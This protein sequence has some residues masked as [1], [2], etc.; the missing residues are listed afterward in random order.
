LR[1]LRVRERPPSCTLITSRLILP[2]AREGALLCPARLPHFLRT[3][4]ESDFGFQPSIDDPRPGGSTDVQCFM[5]WSSRQAGPV[6]ARSA[7][8]R[9]RAWVSFRAGPRPAEMSATSWAH[10][11]LIRVTTH[12]VGCLPASWLHRSSHPRSVRLRR[13]HKIVRLRV[14]EYWR[15]S[16]HD[17]DRIEG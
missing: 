9:I 16:S 1:A 17:C 4:H 3:L 10:S 5:I 8:K 14:M 2:A 11:R 7:F 12:L 13:R 6:D 15:I